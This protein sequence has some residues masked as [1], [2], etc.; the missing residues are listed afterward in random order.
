MYNSTEQ[1]DCECPME[2]ENIISYVFN[3][4]LLAITIY[5]EF[6]GASKCSKSNGIVHGIMRAT[7]NQEVDNNINITR[8][9]SPI[10]PLNK[11]TENPIM[12]Q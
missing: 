3:F 2:Y 10:R 11:D 7:S 1:L 6:S 5:S 9:A 12:V 4:I 8:T